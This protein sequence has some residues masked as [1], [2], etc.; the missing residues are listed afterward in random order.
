M[1]ALDMSE[2]SG[3]ERPEDGRFDISDRTGGAGTSEAIRGGETD[4]KSGGND[5]DGCMNS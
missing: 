4:G 2:G 1:S 5:A 3:C